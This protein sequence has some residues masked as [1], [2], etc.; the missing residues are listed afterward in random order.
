MVH[1]PGKRKNTWIWYKMNVIDVP[2]QTSK[3]KCTLAYT[4]TEHGRSKGNNTLQRTLGEHKRVE[5]N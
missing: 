5:I 4:P 1:T 3:L 2:M